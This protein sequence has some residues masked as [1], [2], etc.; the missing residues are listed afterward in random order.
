MKLARLACFAR[1]SEG[2]V[3]EG[4]AQETRIRGK[5]LPGCAGRKQLNK[6]RHILP[7]VDNFLHTNHRDVHRREQAG[8]ANVSFAFD[9]HQ[10]ARVCRHQIGA[11]T[12]NIGMH[13]FAAQDL[14]GKLCELLPG[15]E[16]EVRLEFSLEQRGDALPA[17]MDCRSD[18]MR[19]LFVRKL[20]DKFGEIALGDFHSRGL[21]HVIQS[22]FFRGD[23][24]SLDDKLCPVAHADIT[25][26]PA[27]FFGPGSEVDMAASPTYGLLQLRNQLR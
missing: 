23:A 11:G 25:H 21:Q 27:G 17:V 10:C 7:A 20:Q 16:R 24:F 13:E 1:Q 2:R 3:I 9:K 5:R 15:I 18:D 14:A 4:W 6:G 26:I 19:R 8:H 22:N 12:P